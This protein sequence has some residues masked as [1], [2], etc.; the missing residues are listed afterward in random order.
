MRVRLISRYGDE[1]AVMANLSQHGCCIEMQEP[2]VQG[3]LIVRWQHFEAHGEISW[4]EENR[5]GVRF[6]QAI[7][8]EWLVETRQLNET[9]GKMCVVTENKEAA[10]AWAEGK[11][12]L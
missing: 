6:Y 8:Y 10:R 9:T 4:V 2:L 12:M 5:I 1:R 3:Q 11:R 7:P